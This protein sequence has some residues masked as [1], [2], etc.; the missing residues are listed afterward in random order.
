MRPPSSFRTLC[1]RHIRN[2]ATKAHT[3]PLLPLTLPLDDPPRL[4]RLPLFPQAVQ[5]SA[6]LCVLVSCG[7]C[8]LSST[9]TSTFIGIF[10]RL[11]IFIHCDIA[12]FFLCVRFFRPCDPFPVVAPC[13]TI[14]PRRRSL[15][16]GSASRRVARVP[17]HRFAFAF[18][19]RDRVS[20]PPIFSI[21]FHLTLAI[22]VTFALFA[23]CSMAHRK[24]FV[25][26]SLPSAFRAFPSM[27]RS[28]S[29]PVFD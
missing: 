17:S 21:S 27:I 14:A 26:F 24:L 6:F 8:F 9:K 29:S 20:H 10:A 16:P 1:A 18:S 5:G 19:F 7:T 11:C 15:T 23:S 13:R 28:A 25:C 12:C 2:F 3:R 22:G 4:F